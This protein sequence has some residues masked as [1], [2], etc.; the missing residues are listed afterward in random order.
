[1]IRIANF[2]KGM[3]KIANL[4]KGMIRIANFFASFT[5]FMQF[6][7]GSSSRTLKSKNLDNSTGPNGTTKL[8]FVMQI[9]NKILSSIKKLLI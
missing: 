3:I 8:C 1:M 9:A 7:P 6:Q 5:W 4:Q 2:Q